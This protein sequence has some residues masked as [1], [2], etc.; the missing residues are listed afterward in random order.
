MIDSEKL[1]LSEMKL[2]GLIKDGD[3]IEWI[4]PNREFVFKLS[5]Y[6]NQLWASNEGQFKSLIE[7]NIISMI[8]VSLVS[9]KFTEVEAFNI[10]DCLSIYVAAYLNNDL[11]EDSCIGIDSSDFNMDS[12][13]ISLAVDNTIQQYSLDKDG[14]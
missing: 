13:M 5:R 2:S 11:H 12:Y 7:L 4:A 10:C 1:V 6:D 8:G 9:I 14:I 3:F